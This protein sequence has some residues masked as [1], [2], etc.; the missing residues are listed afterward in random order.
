[1]AKNL[2]RGISESEL[3]VEIIETWKDARMYWDKLL[4][5]FDESGHLSPKDLVI[6]DGLYS[7]H[8]SRLDTVRELA[9]LGRKYFPNGE[10]NWNKYDV[11]SDIEASWMN[12]TEIL[13]GISNGTLYYKG[14][15]I[16][17][18]FLGLK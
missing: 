3:V 16:S 6:V 5:H 11:N 7:Q 13:K 14:A 18:G 12:P 15:E 10:T 9:R 1:M 17:A 8:V 4:S 2:E